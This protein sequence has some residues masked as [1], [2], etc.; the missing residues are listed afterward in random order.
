MVTSYEYDAFD[1]LVKETREGVQ[2]FGDEPP[3]AA[4]AAVETHY[5]LDTLGRV[6]KTTIPVSGGPD[7]ETSR[8][9][10]DTGRIQSETDEAGLTT[11]YVYDTTAGGGRKVTVTLPGGLTR[12]TE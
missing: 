5:T 12:I 9:Y 11:Q 3:L 4:I 2:A 1:R 10:D 8:V 6:V 7:L